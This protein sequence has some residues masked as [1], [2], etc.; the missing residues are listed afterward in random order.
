[1]IIVIVGIKCWFYS[2]KDEGIENDISSDV[3]SQDEEEIGEGKFG[4]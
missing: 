3:L 1:M 4:L 2:F